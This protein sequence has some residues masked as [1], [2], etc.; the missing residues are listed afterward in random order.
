MQ[1]G[2]KEGYKTRV[3]AA[4]S[5]FVASTSPRELFNTEVSCFEE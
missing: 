1:V 2:E 3:S 4:L 5:F